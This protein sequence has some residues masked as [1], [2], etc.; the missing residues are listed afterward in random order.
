MT[1]W[2]M[3]DDRGVSLIEAL[4]AITIVGVVMTAVASFFMRS[5]SATGQQRG[6][7]IA[8]HLA[9]TG[10]ERVRALKG[11][12]VADGR[13]KGDEMPNL[14][15]VDNMLANTT[16]MNK[17]L[18]SGTPVLPVT[19]ET[20][21]V[22]GLNYLQYWYIG[23]CALPST[24]TVDTDSDGC[25]GAALTDTEAVPVFRVVVAVVWSDRNCARSQ[26]VFVTSSLVSSE[27][28][29]PVFNENEAA[30]PPTI[31]NP[32]NLTGNTVTAVDR[33]FAVTGDAKPLTVSGDNI[34]NGLTLSSGGRVTGT[35]TRV[36]TYSVVIRVTDIRGRVGSASFTWTIYTA[37]K[38]N[39]IANQ[40]TLSGANV[41]LQPVNAGAGEGALTW[42]VTGAVPAGITFDPSTGLLSGS[43]TS[44]SSTTAAPQSV[45]SLAVRLTDS[46]GQF[47]EV[48]FTWTV[49]DW[50]VTALA[51]RSTPRNANVNVNPVVTGG[52]APITWSAVNLPV[53]LSID[54]ATG[55]ITGKPTTKA[56]YGTTVTATD[57]RSQT[58]STSFT[59]TIT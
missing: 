36:G 57:A 43:P 47:S 33:T 38:L 16:R 6:T 55:R 48:S 14:T 1:R 20:V 26:C 24:G 18:T 25:T 15:A 40:T 56:V 45:V 9:D 12:A 27:P 39:P 17:K 37:P 41:N 59:W 53:G 49:N 32:G 10:M 42:S 52:R 4:V 22:A 3:R 50:N 21:T 7:Q 13:E 31:Q 51:G 46:L 29:E 44:G 54:P 58:R 30:P 19:P 8:S 23:A 35:P 11:S 5:I 2:W 28:D 34:P